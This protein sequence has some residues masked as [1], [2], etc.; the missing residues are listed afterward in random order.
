MTLQEDYDELL[1][2]IKNECPEL[3]KLNVDLEALTRLLEIT[4][5]LEGQDETVA[6]RWCLEQFPQ[7]EHSTVH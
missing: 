6:D 3:W 4:Q 1:S 5:W 7:R 2:F